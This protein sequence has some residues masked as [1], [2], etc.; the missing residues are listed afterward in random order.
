MRGELY[1]NCC[2]RCKQ[3]HKHALC[4]KK[5]DTWNNGDPHARVMCQSKQDISKEADDVDRVVGLHRQTT[6]RVNDVWLIMT[7]FHEYSA[8]QRL[9]NLQQIACKLI[10]VVPA[11]AYA[12]QPSNGA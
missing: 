9:A 4:T 1:S 7:T 6:E 10:T 5:S 11:G 12:K 3:Q 8:Q 2:R